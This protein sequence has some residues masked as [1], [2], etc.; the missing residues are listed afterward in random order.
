MNTHRPEIFAVICP[1]LQTQAPRPRTLH[2]SSDPAPGT[3]LFPMTYQKSFPKETVKIG[4]QMVKK[5][6]ETVKIPSKLVQNRPPLVTIPHVAKSLR[7][8]RINLLTISAG[9][10]ITNGMWKGSNF[11]EVGGSHCV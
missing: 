2:S 7:Q 4:P 10:S 1:S 5:G 6:H 9:C 8:T 11:S 3:P